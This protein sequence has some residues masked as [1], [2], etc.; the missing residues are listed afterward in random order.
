[1]AFGIVLKNLIVPLCAARPA[2]DAALGTTI[3]VA[4]V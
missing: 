2:A 3:V 4:G 1:M